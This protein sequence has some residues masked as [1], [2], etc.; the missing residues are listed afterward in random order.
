[1]VTLQS[2]SKN[3]YALVSYLVNED[4]HRDG[5]DRNLYMTTINLMPSAN[6][7]AADYTK[8]FKAE[9]RH[10]SA[11]HKVQMRHMIFSPSSKEFSESSENALE[12]GE[13]VKRYV[14]ENFPNRRAIIA[15]QSDGTGFYLDS[16]NEII[17]NKAGRPVRSLEK[18]KKISRD[19]NIREEHI[20]HAHVALS[21]CDMDDYKGVDKEKTRFSYLAK[22]FDDF[23]V[24]ETGIEIDM[25]QKRGK[26]KYRDHELQVDDK[27]GSKKFASFKDDLADRIDRCIGSSDNMDS[28]YENLPKFGVKLKSNKRGEVFHESKRNGKYVTFELVD[29]SRTVDGERYINDTLVDGEIR[30][31]GSLIRCSLRSHK[32]DKEGYELDSIEARIAS[33]EKYKEKFEDIHELYMSK[34]R[35]NDDSTYED[36]LDQENRNYFAAMKASAEEAD[37][38]RQ[39]ERERELEGDDTP[40]ETSEER[41]ARKE[42]MWAY[43]KRMKEQREAAKRLAEDS[44]VSIVENESEPVSPPVDLSFIIDEVL[45]KGEEIERDRKESSTKLEEDGFGQ[46]HMR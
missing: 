40:I 15:V 8:Q 23:F 17:R 36:E 45:G 39:E 28:F 34:M 9:W 7:D 44:E 33:G 1:M 13:L 29:Q 11:Q 5:V 25:G 24:R 46:F 6:N 21:D 4:S 37:R 38:K 32:F 19:D 27:I 3:G 30:Q 12:F 26:S 31:A 2:P 10:A 22:T 35:R 41:W 20:L 42:A 14:E 18:A 16:Q 43:K